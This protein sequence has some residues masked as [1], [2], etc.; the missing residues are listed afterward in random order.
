V[1]SDRSVYSTLAYQGYGRGLDLDE[2]RTIN[3]WAI[4]GVWPTLVVFVEAPADVI[5]DRLNGRE[6]DRFERAGDEFHERVLDGFRSMADADPDRWVT[7]SA[8]GTKDATAAQILAAVR[9]RLA[10]GE[11]AAGA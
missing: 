7:I 8:D 6:L 5:A 1:V 10:V 9:D 11:G 4:Q 2:L 3:D